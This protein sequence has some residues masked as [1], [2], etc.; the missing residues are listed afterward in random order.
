MDATLDSTLPVDEAQ[1]GS[2]DVLFVVEGHGPMQ[3][4]AVDPSIG[5]LMS[6]DTAPGR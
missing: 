2:F 1:A 6:P 3:D 4:L 5:P